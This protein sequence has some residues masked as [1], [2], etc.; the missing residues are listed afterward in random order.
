[1]IFV[2]TLIHVYIVVYES[3]NI[4]IA[5]TIAIIQVKGLMVL[6]GA[7]TNFETLFHLKL[8]FQCYITPYSMNYVH[9]CTCMDIYIYIYI[10]IYQG[11]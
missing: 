8:L 9:I 2:Y 5:I 1:M 7:T 10:H 11:R 4:T 6:A 3:V